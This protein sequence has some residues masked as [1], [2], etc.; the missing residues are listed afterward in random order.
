MIRMVLILIA[1]MAVPFAIYFFYLLAR[2]GPSGDGTAAKPWDWQRDSVI[3]LGFIGLFLATVGLI[4]VLFM[5]GEAKDGKYTPA[6]IENGKL[7]DGRFNY[8]EGAQNK[9]AAAD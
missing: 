2:S 1:L 9:G 5:G 7:I 3:N 4:A 6:R 8:D